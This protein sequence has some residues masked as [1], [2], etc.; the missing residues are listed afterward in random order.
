MYIIIDAYNFLRVDIGNEFIT[1]RQRERFLALVRAYG[2]KK[3]HIMVVVFDGGE[4]RWPVQQ[5]HKEVKVIYSGT[6]QTADEVII[7]HIKEHLGQAM[8]L[9]SSDRQLRDEAAQYGVE[10]VHARDFWDKLYGIMGYADQEGVRQV[11]PVKT[12]QSTSEQVDLLMQ[13]VKRM[14]IKPEDMP[15]EQEQ[16]ELIPGKQLKRQERKRLQ[17]LKKL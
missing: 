3:K 16:E 8:I 17:K 10:L 4:Y 7:S 2:N 15:Q 9:V 12:A 5:M 14:Q 6:H 1:Q 13:Q 11:K